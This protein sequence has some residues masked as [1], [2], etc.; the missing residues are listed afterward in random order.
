MLEKARIV[1]QDTQ[2]VISVMYNPTELTLGKTVHVQGEGS[3][4]Q[5]Q[6][7]SDDDL[8]VSLF[9]DSSDTRT[10]IRLVTN[11][12]VA[13]TQPTMGTGVRKEPPVVVFTWSDALFTGVVIKLEQKFTMFLSTGVPVRAE[14]TVTFKSV[15]TQQQDLAARGYFN[16][17]KLWTVKEGDR[18]YLIAKKALGDAAQWRLIADANDIYDVISF[19]TPTDIGRTLVIIDT[20]DGVTNGYGYANV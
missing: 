15:L 16:C 12:L 5:F 11:R 18:L 3:N 20:H 17:R 4:I 1:V 19:P 7:V 9:F 10:D 6:R 2:E 8:T 14:L 13:L